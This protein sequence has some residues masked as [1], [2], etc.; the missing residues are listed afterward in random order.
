MMNI[1][2]KNENQTPAVSQTQAW[3]P[4]QEMRSL[5]SWDP[6][7][8][9]R[10][11]VGFDFNPAFEVKENKDGFLFKADVPGVK[12]A[13]IDVNLQG[14]RLL[15]S[16]KREMEKTEQTDTVYTWERGY[17]SFQ[18]AFTLPQGVDINHAKAEL[19][20]GVLMVFIPRNQEMQTKKI[21]VKSATTKV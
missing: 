7:K 13:D 12:E 2:K 3:D 16:G 19:K 8:S 6:F 17:G 11:A 18:R 1:M 15:I 9:M 14:D 10:P 21:A 20:D 4:F 5:L